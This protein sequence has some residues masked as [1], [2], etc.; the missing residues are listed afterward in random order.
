MQRDHV[1]TIERCLARLAPG[2]L[3]IFSNNF[4]RFRLDAALA[5]GRLGGRRLRVEE[6]S[7][8][9][10]GRDFRRSPRIHRVWFIEHATA[11]HD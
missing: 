2:G 4:R 6:R 11:S 5:A 3:L 8:R 7:R 9:S 10:L 1:S